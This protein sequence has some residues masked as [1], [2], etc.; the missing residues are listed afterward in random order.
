[1]NSMKQETIGSQNGHQWEC[2]NE[3]ATKQKDGNQNVGVV[4]IV[5]K[6]NLLRTYTSSWP[7]DHQKYVCTVCGILT[8][9]MR[10]R[11]QDLGIGAKIVTSLVRSS[12]SVFLSQ[13][14]KKLVGIY[15]TYILRTTN[16]S[17][18]NTKSQV[19]MNILAPGMIQCVISS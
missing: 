17:I 13:L 19:C 1:M 2:W 8:H 7:T 15:D 18:Y 3:P 9:I 5:T 11:R 4:I 6:V 16:S 14:P 12:P 10:R